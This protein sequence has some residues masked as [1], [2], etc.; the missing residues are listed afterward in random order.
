LECV[1]AEQQRP[2]ALSAALGIAPPDKLFAVQ[3][4]DHEPHSPV[5]LIPA[6]GA[7]RDDALDTVLARQP[8]KG[9]AV[10]N[11]VIVVSQRVRRILQQRCQPGLAVHQRPRSQILP[12]QVEQIDE[13]EDERSLAA[14]SRVLDEVEGRATIG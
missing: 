14:V 2:N 9:R 3:V 4:L 7:L 5:G 8:M 13:E 10:A 6:I 12:V 11:L 1:E